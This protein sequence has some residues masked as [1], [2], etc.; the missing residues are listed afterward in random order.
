MKRSV[1]SVIRQSAADWDLVLVDDGSTDDTLAL[2]REYASGDKRIKVLHQDNA[3]VTAAR[4]AGFIQSSGEF[5]CF[6]DADDALQPSA[7]E[8]MSAYAA[9][10]DA[11]VV[12]C[13]ERILGGDMAYTYAND[14][15]GRLQAEEYI[16][17]VYFTRILNTLH[18]SIYRRELLTD[19]MFR[20][21]RRYKLGEDIAMN[22]MIANR[23]TRAYV[24]NDTVY[25][26]YYN[27]ASAM[28][29]Q[30]MSYE[31]NKAIGDFIYN[32]VVRKTAA[33]TDSHRPEYRIPQLMARFFF[34]PEIPFS[35]ERY[36]VMRDYLRRPE[37][38]THFEAKVNVTYR[39][40][41]DCKPLF[42]V[43][44]WLY[45]TFYLVSHLKGKKRK[46]L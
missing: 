30:V 27:R 37:V 17:A 41:I 42:R 7:L 28:Q 35:N 13:T 23:V 26:Y 40:F 44:S 11:D 29:T 22:V 16:E 19:D 9:R 12:K 33:I 4:H 3:G 21:D 8:T 6:L 43:Y 24:C 14:V 18:A 2:C 1:E 39:R 20:I 5:V 25:D 15:T 31:Y 45:K 10:Y 34:I 32:A 46:V 38:R 36:T